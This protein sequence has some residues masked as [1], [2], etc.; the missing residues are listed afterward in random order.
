MPTS[1]IAKIA[2]GIGTAALLLCLATGAGIAA[3]KPN[4]GAGG[5]PAGGGGGRPAGGGGGH[6]AFVGGGGHPAFV[7]GGGHPSFAVQRGGVAHFAP[8]VNLSRRVGGISH[9]TSRTRIGRIGRPSFRGRFG[10]HVRTAHITPSVRGTR[11]AAVIYHATPN[12][13]RNAANLHTL[14]TGATGTTDPRN[15]GAHRHLAGDPAFRPFLG[16]GWHPHHHLGWIGP[17]FW[18]YAYGDFFYYALWPYD[19]AYYDPFW[20]YGYDDIYEGIFSPYNYD[21]YVQGPSAPA[22]MTA[23]TQ[24]VAQS[25]TDEAA[26]VTG[27]PID[28]IQAARPPNARAERAARRSRQRR[29]Q[30]ERRDQV[31]LS[32][33]RLVYADRPSRRYAAAPRRADAGGEYRPA[34]P[35]EVL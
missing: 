7:S 23:L 9:F 8:H 18:P 29:R 31:A 33:A 14:T 21:E 13:G 11:G 22:R 10:S 19:Y 6:P 16:P 1:K 30:G 25:C 2:T 3:G 28:Q 32:D 35:G 12:V 17:L 15:F 27:W 34:A 26:E 20:Y 24:S 5:H 4:P